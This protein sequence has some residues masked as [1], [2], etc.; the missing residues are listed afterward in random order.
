MD[1]EVTK[2]AVRVF[3]SAKSI[4]YTVSAHIYMG[5]NKQIYRIC[6]S[7]ISYSVHHIQDKSL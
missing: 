4:I 3:H 7:Y 6:L 1:R 2:I 5:M